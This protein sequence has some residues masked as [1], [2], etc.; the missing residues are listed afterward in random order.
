MNKKLVLKLAFSGIL[1]T[2]SVTSAWSYTL[3]SPRRTW[4]SPPTF[5]IDNRGHASVG[6]S[7]RGVTRTVNALRSPVGW[8]SAGCGT[9]LNAV[10]GSMLTF[11]LGDGIPMINFRDPFG[12]CS[13]SC[14]VATF[15][16]Y[17]ARRT[18]GTYRITDADMVTNPNHDLAS[19]GEAVCSSEIFVESLFQH[20]VGHALGLGHSTVAGATMYPAIPAC[21]ASLVSIEEDDRN[22]VRALYGCS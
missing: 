20:E 19:A 7:D 4:D 10:A 14:I 22:A 9:L 17:Y 18:D 1:A 21:S 15:T 8:N 16:G 5:I 3:L 12:A 2:L 6:D 13:G 11:R